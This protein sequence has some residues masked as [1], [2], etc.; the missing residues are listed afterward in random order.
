MLA[1]ACEPAFEIVEQADIRSGASR[2]EVPFDDNETEQTQCTAVEQV[3]END[4]FD[5][6]NV[7]LHEADV[8]WSYMSL[9]KCAQLNG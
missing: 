6:L 2:L 1:L 7:E 9:Q 8:T 4:P 3:W 5:A